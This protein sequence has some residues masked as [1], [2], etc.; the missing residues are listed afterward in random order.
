MASIAPKQRVALA[1]FGCFNPPTYQHLRLFELAR[2]SLHKT[3][4]YEVVK[5]MISPVHDNYAKKGLIPSTHRVA[6]LR[7][8]VETSDWI[9][10]NDWET[11]QKDWKLTNSVLQHLQEELDIEYKDKLPVPRVVL[12]CGADLLKSFATPD[13]WSSKDLEQIL[14]NNG[15]VVISREDS[16]AEKFVYESDQLSAWYRRI[17]FVREWVRHDLSSTKVRQCVKRGDSIKYLT[18]DSIISYIKEH[19]LYTE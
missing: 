16:D 15:I 14:E 1:L 2:D 3:G 18:P 7:L 12:L 9:F 10:V 11:K 5:G 4:R 17:V 13:L 8:S 19:G 6:M